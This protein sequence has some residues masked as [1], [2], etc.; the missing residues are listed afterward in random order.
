M[1]GPGDLGNSLAALRVPDASQGPGPMPARLVDALDLQLG[2][3]ITHTLAGA[4]SATGTGAGTELSQLRAYAPGDDVRHVDAAASARTAT[5]QVRVH[6]PERALTTW[7]VIDLSPSMAF[8]TALRLKS[9]VAH[10][11]ALVFA[12]LGTRRAGNVGA[13]A[14]G[15]PDAF[16]GVRV[17]A[18]RGARR[19]LVAVRRLLDAGVAA[20]SDTGR[21]EGT[22]AQAAERVLRLARL[23]G[24][25]VV[26]SDFRDQQGWERPLGALRLRHAVLAVEVTDPG[27]S[28]LPR[29][30]RLAL[31]DPESGVV[32]RA[33]TA[34]RRL[35]ERFAALES[36]RREALSREL[37]RLAI[38]HVTLSTA[39]DW[40]AALGRGIR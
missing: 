39:D 6:V 21:R 31:V 3:L 16:D 7:L 5:L 14:F 1:T 32:V 9:D 27:E 30:G 8:G 38:R 25:V 18:P 15:V 24:L 28:A 11:A 36:E 20:D 10:G 17:L 37:R 35:G 2:R 40:L 29:L 34:D 26:I 4:R 12:R 23:P 13:V 19:G 33:D 22:L